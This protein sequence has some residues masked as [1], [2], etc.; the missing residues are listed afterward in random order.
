M[1]VGVVKLGAIGTAVL[2]E[3][4][5]DEIA[6]REDIDTF[7]ISSGSK[8]KPEIL[9]D[10]K[11]ENFDLLIITCPNAG[12]ILEPEKLRFKIRTVVVT[13]SAD[14][15]WLES[16]ECGYIVV[17]ADSM[18]GAKRE[19]LDPT[20]MALYNSYVLGVLAGTGVIRLVQHEINRALKEDYI[21]KVVVDCWKAVEFGGFSNP[22]AKAKAMAGYVIAETVSKLTTRACFVERDFERFVLLC[23]TAHEMMRIANALVDQAREIEKSNDT[24]LRTPHSKDGGILRKTE[25]LERI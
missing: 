14:K 3:Y 16:V 13:D 12:R 2:L 7:V 10:I 22:Y 19:F 25:L 18:I 24:V 1:R 5:L 6:R 17:K 4:C 11:G 21:P 20:E 15:E 9:E 8:I 23:A